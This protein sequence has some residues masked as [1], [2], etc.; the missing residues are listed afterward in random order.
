MNLEEFAKTLGLPGLVVLVWY[1]LEVRRAKAFEIIEA[2]RSD[3][4][5]AK[6]T[7]M[8]E[9]FRSLSTQI[10]AHETADLRSH[11]EM[12]TALGRIEKGLD[13]AEARADRHDTPAQGVRIVRNHT[14]GDR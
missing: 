14:T 4:E 2:R 9:G 5:E 6:V 12:A 10:Q 11:A 1:L 3:V 13:I 8:G 7:A